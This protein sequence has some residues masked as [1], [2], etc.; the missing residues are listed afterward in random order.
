MA[1]L[2]GWLNLNAAGLKTVYTLPCGANNYTIIGVADYNARGPFSLYADDGITLLAGPQAGNVFSN[3]AGNTGDNFVIGVIN[4]FNGTPLLTTITLDNGTSTIDAQVDCV[5]TLGTPMVCSATPSADSITG[6]SYLWTSPSGI[7]YYQRGLIAPHQPAENGVW[8][9]SAT[10]SISGCP[11]TLNNSIVLSNCGLPPLPLKYNYVRA[12]SR[13]CNIL[14]EW[15]T[16]QEENSD[17]FEIE[18]SETGSDGWQTVGSTAAAGSSALGR[19]Y[20]MQIEYPGSTSFVR[21]KQIDRDGRYTYS[22]VIK[23]KVECGDQRDKLFLIRGSASINQITLRLESSSNRG[24]GFIVLFDLSGRPL[25]RKAISINRAMNQYTV[26]AESL[27]KGVYF[28]RIF[29]ARGVWQ[30][31]A[32]TIIVP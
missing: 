23:V 13:N 31:N 5:C 25:F 16:A 19:S 30:T 21:L 15:S 11:Y 27:T 18:T 17:R 7:Q 3:V 22:S 6:A 12:S 24:E 28:V 14:V 9:I 2:G 8:T 1:I 4:V 29:T 26:N 20:T 32:I 10:F